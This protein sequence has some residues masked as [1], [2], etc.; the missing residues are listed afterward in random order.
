MIQCDICNMTFDKAHK[1]YNHR[2]YYKGNCKYKIEEKKERK[3][4][5][6][7]VDKLN[8]SDLLAALQDHDRNEKASERIKELEILNKNLE[9]KVS[10]CFEF[11][12]Y[13]I[14]KS[15]ETRRSMTE[16]QRRMILENQGYKCAGKECKLVSLSGHAYDIDHIIPLEFGGPDESNNLQAL[17]VD[18]HRNKTDFER[19]IRSSL[20]SG[21]GQSVVFPD[22][23]PH[24]IPNAIYSS[25]LSIPILVHIGELIECSS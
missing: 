3:R 2:G 15:V 12:Q 10:E 9:S 13:S 8:S 18:C 22:H 4:K 23:W 24:V 14:P 21:G 5:A 25:N 17:C 1:L 19:T 7:Q 16:P 6:I 11:P 20:Q